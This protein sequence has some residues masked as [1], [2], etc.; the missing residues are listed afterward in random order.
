VGPEIIPMT[1]GMVAIGAD[2]DH[3]SRGQ[4]RGMFDSLNSFFTS[5]LVNSDA[6]A[7]DLL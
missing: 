5:F 7:P 1:L 6:K 2:V 4:A 3:L